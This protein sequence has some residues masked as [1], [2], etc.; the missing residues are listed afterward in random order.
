[1][2]GMMYIKNFPNMPFPGNERPAF[3][4]QFRGVELD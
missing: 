4:K 2:R 1:M 3:P